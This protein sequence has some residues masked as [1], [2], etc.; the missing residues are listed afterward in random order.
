M[1]GVEK[2][3]VQAALAVGALGQRIVGEGLAHFQ[4]LAAVPASVFIDWH[5]D[6]KKWLALVNVECQR[7]RAQDRFPKRPVGYGP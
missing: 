4:R 6:S 2:I 5:Q 3:L 1:P 7:Y